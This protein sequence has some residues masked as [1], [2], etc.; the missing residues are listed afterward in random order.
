MIYSKI[1]GTGAYLPQ[2]IMTNADLEK[3]VNTSDDW[4]QT[5]TGIKTRHIA[6]EG[7]S[8]SDMAL[9]A[10]QIAIDTAG[11]N[12]NEIGLIVLATSTPDQI[13]PSTACLLQNHLEI[14]NNC[15]AFDIQ[16]VCAGFVYALSVA[17][18]FMKSGKI[19]YALVIGSEC[20]SKIL[21]WNDRTTCVLFGDGAGAIILKVADE[22]GVIN[23]VLHAD[24]SY[25]QML[26]VP[27]GVSKPGDDP[28]IRMQGREVFKF[29]VQAMAKIVDE[30]L[31][32]T[33]MKKEDIDWL[34][35][36][37]ANQRI[38][39]ATSEKLQLPMSKVIMTVQD[40]GNT[41]AA[42]IPLALDV[43]IRDGRIKQG[44]TLL[45]EAIGG[46]FA[47]GANLLRY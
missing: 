27:C 38:I 1:I 41:S 28:F 46:G 37:Q 34:I 11:I 35:P 18:N 16:A 47:W 13:F 8:T 45:F 39:T 20:Y 14:R 42:S 44:E 22:P 36:H 19:K 29:A 32:S 6:D 30:T 9:Q 15:A 26:Q 2:R 17:D 10:S 24:G 31:Q 33:G 21:D 12:K 40:H 43:G 4:I 25:N 7:E 3:M 5:R 23:S